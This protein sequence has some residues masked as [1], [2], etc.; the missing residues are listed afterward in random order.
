MRKYDVFGKRISKNRAFYLLILIFILLM[1]SYFGLNS[2]QNRRLDALEEERLTLEREIMIYKRQQSESVYASIDQLI[3][4]L[5][6]T[7]S[8]ADIRRKMEVIRLMAGIDENDVFSMNFVENTNNPFD[9]SMPS[10]LSY[11]LINVSFQSANKTT[12]TKLLDELEASTTFFY[13]HDIRVN[14]LETGISS[15]LVLY[16]FYYPTT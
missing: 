16:T 15:T 4:R 13:V 12:L 5:P 11:V 14:Y 8:Q 9:D 1:G 6:T 10:G 7:F 2:V 3:D